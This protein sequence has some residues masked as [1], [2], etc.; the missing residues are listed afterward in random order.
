MIAPF[1]FGRVGDYGVIFQ[2]GTP[3]PVKGEHSP[4][5]EENILSAFNQSSGEAFF[6]AIIP[7]EV[8]SKSFLEKASR[9]LTKEEAEL[10]QNLS[11]ARWIA[12]FVNTGVDPSLA[13][14][15]RMRNPGDLANLSKAYQGLQNYHLKLAQEKDQENRAKGKTDKI[16]E[17]LIV[18][19]INSASQGK[20]FGRVF[21]LVLRTNNLREITAAIIQLFSNIGKGKK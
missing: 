10:H 1:K 2:E 9:Q 6:F 3:W 13:A 14:Y 7:D 15:V 5:K 4:N 21:S 8:I 18:R 16:S 17:E 20:M 19:R 12:G 11:Q